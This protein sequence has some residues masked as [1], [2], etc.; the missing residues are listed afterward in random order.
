M[1][2]PVYHTATAAHRAAVNASSD[3]T[4]R[5]GEILRSLD[6]D[7]L[8]KKARWEQF[9][10]PALPAG[11]GVGGKGE[12]SEYGTYPVFKTEVDLAKLAN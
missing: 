12:Q 9:E 1:T 8:V 3:L 5:P 4:L 11:V 6:L 7:D 2:H 10:F